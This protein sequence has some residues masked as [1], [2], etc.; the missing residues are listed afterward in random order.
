MRR[1]GL[2]VFIYYSIIMAIFQG[3]DLGIYT[4]YG[5]IVSVFFFGFW[6]LLSSSLFRNSN[7]LKWV[8]YVIYFVMAVN[9]LS[10]LG[11]LL[12]GMKIALNR[13]FD[14]F[15]VT[16][17]RNFSYFWDVSEKNAVSYMIILLTLGLFFYSGLLI[18]NRLHYKR[19]VFVSMPMMAFL[20]VFAPKPIHGFILLYTG[21]IIAYYYLERY[22][23]KF[24]G[25]VFVMLFLCGLLYT[26][27]PSTEVFGERMTSTRQAIII[28]AEYANNII[29]GKQEN[30]DLN[31][32]HFHEK[33]IEKGKST[34]NYLYLKSVDDEI[35]LRAWTGSDYKK[36]EWV[37]EKNAEMISTFSEASGDGKLGFLKILIGD[38][39]KI[40]KQ[41]MKF[42]YSD[43]EKE[44]SLIPYHT[45]YRDKESGKIYYMSVDNYK[46]LIPEIKRDYKMNEK[47]VK[48]PKKIE[49]RLSRLTHN[50]DISKDSSQRE[51]VNF[52]LDFMKNNY[53][54]VEEG[55][56][57]PEGEDSVYYFLNNSKRGGKSDYV[58]AAVFLLRHYG[59]AAR[60]VE[61]YHLTED[62]YAQ[63]TMSGGLVKASISSKDEEVWA[64]IY[65]NRLGWVPLEVIPSAVSLVAASDAREIVI[66]GIPKITMT[67]PELLI[68]SVKLAF[69]VM[70][71]LCV[72]VLIIYEYIDYKKRKMTNNEIIQWYATVWE[73]Y[74][75]YTIPFFEVD[76]LIEVARYSNH[77]LDQYDV[78]VV[79]E[80]AQSARRDYRKS[81]PF[82][83]A[84]FDLF[85]MCRDV[86]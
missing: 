29:C 28:V 49:N 52:V 66:P 8:G 26:L 54:L 79:L 31:L 16:F 45:L 38:Q 55:T 82:Y 74:R 85:I 64:E 43:E 61:G 69:I 70:A 53:T 78:E 41:Y 25:V 17:H 50:G 46:N 18:L 6:F 9:V 42:E 44:D 72:R 68:W 71:I 60:Y 81:I 2:L 80:A 21:S 4:G 14:V 67:L 15:N 12:I 23:P 7:I 24:A 36:G 84:F 37:E 40:T 75:D 1:F 76:H 30:V 62:T 86:L 57:T 77:E 83:L 35:Y 22:K 73:H 13:T 32:Q 34:N 48:V 39:T 56:D 3:F 33:A 58:S 5:I 10:V 27:Y 63:A 19:I 11:D 51:I 20:M 59:I 65:I 47:Y